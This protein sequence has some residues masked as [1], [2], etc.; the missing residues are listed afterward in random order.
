MENVEKED[1]I[2]G[3]PKVISFDCTEEIISQMK[4]NI[5]KIKIDEINK[6][7]TGFFCKI[8]FPDENN[9][10]KVLITNNHIINEDILYKENQKIPIY[11]K[12]EKKE[13]FLN[14]NNRIKYT[15]HEKQYDITIIEIKDTDEINNFLELDKN[16]L[17]DILKDE[18]END[19]Y[20]DKTFYI[21]QYPE[22]ELSVS[23][24]IISNICLDKK[25]K[26]THL[27]G[28]KAGSSGSP[29]LN[30]KNKLI[31]IHLETNKSK[32]FGTFL[33]Y[34]IK[35]FIKKNFNKNDNNN[36]M[37]IIDEKINEIFLNHINKKFKL[38]I[39]NEYIINYN[40][41]K[42]YLGEDGFKKL[43]EV[44]FYYKNKICSQF[45]DSNFHKK[46]IEQMEK[47][48]CF[49]RTEGL[50]GTGFFCRI[51]FPDNN[52]MLKVLITFSPLLE[53]CK[54]DRLIL[55]NKDDYI[56]L[57]LNHRKKY[58]NKENYVAIIEIKEEDGI[59]DFL[60]LDDKII[61]DIIYNINENEEYLNSDIDIYLI[62]YIERNNLAVS[63]GKLFSHK[64]YNDDHNR[65][66][67]NGDDEQ[68]S[69][70]SPILNLNNKVI[71]IHMGNSG[72][73]FKCGRFLNSPIKEFIESIYY[74][75][76]KE[77]KRP[78][79]I[80]EKKNLPIKDNPNKICNLIKDNI[81]PEIY[82]ELN[83]LSSNHINNPYSDHIFELRYLE[84]DTYKAILYQMENCICK[85][86]IENNETIGFFC[87]LPLKKMFLRILI[88]NNLIINEE[89]LI[90]K[91]LLIEFP[92]EKEIKKIA[93]KNRKKY[94]N[95]EYNTTII[96]IKEEDKINKFL[97]LDED[98][99]EMINEKKD[100]DNIYNKLYH[101]LPDMSMYTINK[102]IEVF[103]LTF[104]ICRCFS[105]E[106]KYKLLIKS[107][108]NLMTIG[109]PIFNLNNKLIGV[110]NYFTKSCIFCICSLLYYP[111]KEYIDK[112]YN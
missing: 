106:K 8:P 41:I 95:K 5:C 11:I 1:E 21:I 93:L 112:N 44:Y 31:G 40:P 25:Y 67:H 62:Q 98:L 88:T 110:L 23:Y 54:D 107:N 61:N 94:T 35:D 89:T 53:K 91:E 24:G 46:V 47:C 104:S 4:K 66:R 97:E 20:K 32:N 73:H 17:N 27:C 85:I 69:S 101:C 60:E 82:K 75:N 103:S 63:F 2:T 30:L 80:N 33:N 109:A 92:N 58:I 28:T 38:D 6:Q 19:D 74:N 86:K 3:Y 76:D 57:N 105:E 102:Q 22:G 18:N 87:V 96:E 64:I 59:N 9:M 43:K 55:N 108:K 16:I 26:F 68:N 48:I 100:A 37:N 79:E 50:R 78:K 10:L 13:R 34:P 7:G 99:V 56:E 83:E 39:K 36:K 70:G 49:I 81:G 12:E 84:L 65:F 90:K 52:N 15:N 71:G 111:L 29:I 45:L 72:R 42:K 77:K 14:L 51:P